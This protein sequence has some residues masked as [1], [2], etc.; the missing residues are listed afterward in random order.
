MGFELG[1]QCTACDDQEPRMIFEKMDKSNLDWG[2]VQLLMI[3]GYIQES[4]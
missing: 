2:R 3:S 4:F 1:T